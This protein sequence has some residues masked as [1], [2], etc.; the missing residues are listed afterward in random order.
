M[1]ASRG[2]DA[3]GIVVYID[4]DDGAVTFSVVDVTLLAVR[5]Q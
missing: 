2:Y 3:V 1:K 4:S 5:Q